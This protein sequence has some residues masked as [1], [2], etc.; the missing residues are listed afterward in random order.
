MS[1]C[2]KRGP[3]QDPKKQA[4]ILEKA[5]AIVEADARTPGTKARAAA[6]PAM[7][8]GALA[9]DSK[10]FSITNWL[11]NGVFGRDP[12]RAKFE[13]AA[14][15][16]FKKG[17]E[18]TGNMLSGQAGRFWYPTD[19]DRFSD[20]AL[21][22]DD[23]KYCKAVLDASPI[24]FDPDE[25]AY[26]VKKS[27]ILKTQSAYADNLGGTLVPPPT[28]GP[29]IPLIRPNAALIAAGA[30]QMTLPPSGRYQEPRITA[31]P[32][33][34]AAAESADPPETDLNTDQMELSAKKIA[35]LAR[36]TEE[37]VAFTSG[38]VDAITKAE[39]D[40]SLGLKFDAYGFYGTGTSAIPAGLTSA[41]YSSAVINVESAY[42]TSMGVDTN[43]NTLLPEYGDYLPA[44]IE[45]RSFGLDSKDGAWVMRPV[46]YAAAVGARA[47]AVTAG[48][49]AGPL[50]DILRRFEDKGP[51]QWRGRKVV[52][53]TNV[54]GDRTKGTGTNL[55]DAFFGIWPYCVVAT[56]GA[57]QFT[58]GHDANSFA[59]G[60]FLIRGVMFGDIGFR[61]P[62]AFLHF[63]N[64]LGVQGQL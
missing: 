7:V 47:S 26:L 19:W 57:V 4:A 41:A 54:R 1:E 6:A 48:D 15:E 49:G 12:A 37:A 34:M 46:A 61:Y 21:A 50:V 9:P 5:A 35:G 31:A 64:V 20:D 8:K 32:S 24:Q 22:H 58:Q 60:Q 28:M 63:P 17:L 44:L 25:Y 14:M 33:V 18:A 39:L 16:R 2:V 52:R 30:T 59:R 27:L 43:G 29:V 10:R 40:R 13:L 56:Y 38:T 62:G 36:V 23:V 42:P 11:V 51:N 3:G 55:S 53:T 45:D